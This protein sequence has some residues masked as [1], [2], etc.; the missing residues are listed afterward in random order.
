WVESG[1]GA[2]GR[3]KILDFGLV[4]ALAGE[5]NGPLGVVLGTPAYMAPEQATGQVVD[6]RADL[7]S[8]G[9]V[10]YRM[11]TGRPP[12]EAD[13]VLGLLRRVCQDGP[14]PPRRLNPNL[15]ADLERVILHLLRK[16]PDERPESARAVVSELQALEEARRPKPS[17][18]RWLIGTAAVVLAAA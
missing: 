18:R 5:A 8:L 15:P 3:I 11:T 16:Q 14:P 4:Q 13:D 6:G 7:F 12:F 2:A 10:L 9:C 17:R 1:A